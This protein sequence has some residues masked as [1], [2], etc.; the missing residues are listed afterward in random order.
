MELFLNKRGAF[1]HPHDFNKS[2][3]RQADAAQEPL[4]HLTSWDSIHTLE[5]QCS[6]Q[7]SRNDG[8]G[9]EA[10]IFAT[11]QIFERLPSSLQEVEHRLTCSA[12]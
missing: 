1:N 3:P 4:L 11:H 6:N 2:I 8:F 10:T 12:D 9:T 7:P 5:S